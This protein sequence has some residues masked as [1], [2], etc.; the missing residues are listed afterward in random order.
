MNIGTILTAADMVLLAVM[1]LFMAYLAF[2]SILALF[3]RLK[4]DFPSSRRR[5]FAVVIPAHNEELVIAKPLRTLFE[6][7]YPREL[8]DVI[9]VADN[10][11]DRTATVAR[12]SGAMVF[13]REDAS[14]RGKG[15]ALSWCFERLLSSPKV[16]EAYVVVDADCEVTRNALAVFNH[17]LD[18]G[19]QSMQCADV[20]A[21]HPGAW[22]SEI[23]RLAFTLYNIVRPRG[24]A[25]IGC[26]AGLRGNGMCF[27]AGT[28]RQVPWKAYSLTE[29]LE[30]GLMLLLEGI[31]V[32][33]APEAAVVNTM[34]LEPRQSRTQ[35]ARWEAGRFPVVKHYAPTL[36]RGAVRRWSFRLLDA[37][38]DLVMPPFVNM[39]LVVTGVAVIHIAALLLG[40][41]DLLLS[42]WLWI[43]VFVL[44][45]VHV[46]A[47]LVAVKAD[48]SLY[49]VLLYVPR[50]A[51]WKIMLYALMIVKG[52][53]QGWVRTARKYQDG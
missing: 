31:P 41:G 19:A 27:A 28:L 12:T 3:S 37:F 9:V 14:L 38:V 24:R 39:F 30:Y 6:S 34:P 18:G 40:G 49:K 35:R 15:Y 52:G 50:Y 4:K 33:F 16:Y 44:G 8:F 42:P 47:G 7:D 48:R 26:S 11:T 10:C 29:D 46:F 23:V 45:M 51:V 21:P 53:P 36:L 43:I 22:N 2:L 1:G 32:V 13:E 5:L 17:Y 25:V 20:V